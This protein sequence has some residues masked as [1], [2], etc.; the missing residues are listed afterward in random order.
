MKKL[1]V[2]IIILNLLFTVVHAQQPTPEPIP[3][4]KTDTT[5]Q[6]HYGDRLE[7]NPLYEKKYPLWVPA[8]EVIGFNAALSLADKHV[9]KY[10][11]AQVNTQTWKKNLK[12]SWEWDRDLF[13]V[14]FIGHPYSGS[15]YYN[16]ARSNGYNFAASIPFAIGG[17]LMWEYFGETTRPSYNDIIATPVA[18]WFIGEILYRISS[19]ILNDRKRGG[20]RVLRE[21]SAA[22]VNPMRGFNRVLQGKVTRVTSDTTYQDDLLNLS[23]FGGMRRLNEGTEFNTGEDNAF[24][25]LSVFYGDPFENRIRKPF[26][27]F[28]LR[29]EFNFQVG[30]KILDNV[31]G[32]GLLTGRNVDTKNFKMLYG[33]FQHYNYWSNSTFELGMV[34]FGGGAATKI[35][36]K[37]SAFYNNVYVS[38]VPLAGNSARKAPSDSAIYRN[39]N[40]SGGLEV[41]I[42]SSFDFRNILTLNLLGYYY[43]LYNYVG[44][45]EDSHIS[46]IKPGISFTLYKNIRAGFEHLLYINNLNHE[47]LRDLRL[48]STEQ[49]VFVLIYFENSRQLKKYDN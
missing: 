26:D 17:S 6:T 19:N 33:L 37:K 14:N 30:K 31:T 40:Y 34:T 5:I 10:D 38:A 13:G 44:P 46:L 45:K 27:F 39:Y 25:N 42:E 2:L 8:A 29:T 22:I 48:S 7:D 16:A 4:A 21:T 24:L 18:G 41:K 43:R 1:S 32:Y 35:A 49:K 11:W 15:I 47:K 28:K 3:P 9:L 12:G 36:M 23:I 20:A